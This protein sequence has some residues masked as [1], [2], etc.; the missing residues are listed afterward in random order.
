[1]IGRSTAHYGFPAP[2]AAVDDSLCHL[3]P[4]FSALSS[5]HSSSL[6]PSG[7]LYATSLTPIHLSVSDRSTIQ[8]SACL[9]SLHRGKSSSGTMNCPKI[10]ARQNKQLHRMGRPENACRSLPPLQILLQ[11]KTTS[12]SHIRSSQYIPPR[13]GR[14]DIH[15][16]A[17]FGPGRLPAYQPRAIR[18]AMKRCSC[19]A[20]DKHAVKR[21]IRVEVPFLPTLLCRIISLTQTCHTLQQPLQKKEEEDWRR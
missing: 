2:P 15:P 4:V 13:Q 17:V 11:M 6:T 3:D 18:S 19:R 1:M 5:T 8:K 14:C 9:Y 7:T 12:A 10:L 16:E 21:V 20:Y